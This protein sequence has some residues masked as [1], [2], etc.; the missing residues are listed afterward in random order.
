M[1]MF[2]RR[3]HLARGHWH[4]IGA[5]IRRLF[6][7][8]GEVGKTRWPAKGGAARVLSMDTRSPLDAQA[9]LNTAGG[10]QVP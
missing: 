5:G 1:S 3:S 4:I 6:A 2:G 7:K 10:K 8:T 9:V